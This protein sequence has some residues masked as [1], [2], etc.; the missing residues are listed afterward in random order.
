MKR[1]A[2]RVRRPLLLASRE[3]FV[4]QARLRGGTAKAPLKL[5]HSFGTH[6]LDA[7]HAL[8]M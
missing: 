2:L 7:R 6:C 8:L 1:D 4:E 3:I 5:V